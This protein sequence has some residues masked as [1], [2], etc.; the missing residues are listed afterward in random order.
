MIV[1]MKDTTWEVRPEFPRPDF[2]R[3]D[4]HNLNGAWRFAFD[5]EDV[6]LAQSWPVDGPPGERTIVVPFSWASPL[7]GIGE[8]VRG[9]GWYTRDVAWQPQH[10]DGRVILRFGAVDYRAD[11][12]VN[13][14]HVGSHEGG[15]APFDLDITPAWR[16]DGDNR[17]VVRVE[18]YDLPHQTR[19]KQGY[20]E[21]RGI[22]QPV[23]LEGRPAN[24]LL[25]VRFVTHLDGTVDVSGTIRVH[26]RGRARLT[27]SFPD[28][29]VAHAVE[30]AL[31]E[32]GEAPF[33]TSFRVEEPRLWSPDD[34][35]LYEGVVRLCTMADGADE[36]DGAGEADSAGEIDEVRTY[37]G[38]REIRAERWD[39]RP[40]RWL[41]LNGK[42]VFL[43]G[44]LDQSFHPEG[45]FTFPSDE[46]MRDE[47]WR[48]KRLGLNCV[49]IHIKPEDPRKLYWADKLGILVMAD[50]PCFW[51]EPT[52]AARSAY[53]REAEAVIHR[54]FNHPSI[55]AW[56][57]FNE[58]WGLF[59]HVDGRR[60]YTEETKAWV[61]EV[62]RWAKRL[63]PTRLVE[64]NSACNYD[65][66]ESD[67]NTWHFYIHGYEAVRDHVAHAVERTY[68]G[69]DWNYAEGYVQSDAPLMN[70]E[71]GAVWGVEGSAGDSDL[72]W[73][74]HYM[75]NEF[76]RHDKLCGFVFT[77]FHDV[78]N[79][80][81]GYYRL[82]RSDKDF[83]YPWF[84]PS[85]S[86]RTFHQ[87]DFL[88][89]DGPPCR[90]VK[91]GETVRVPV[92]KSSF[93]DTHH[94]HDLRLRWYVWYDHFGQRRIVAA[95]ERMVHWD[96][97]GVAPL[98]EIE[99]AMPGEDALAVLVVRLETPDGR[100]VAA[101]FTTFDVQSGVPGGQY[102]LP[103]RWWSVAPH[104][105]TEASF[106]LAWRALGGHKANFAHAGAVTYEVALPGIGPLRQ[107][108]GIDIF[109][110]ASAKMVLPKDERRDAVDVAA[111][112]YMQGDRVDPGRNPNSYFM[113]DEQR[114]PSWLE[115][116]VD[117]ERVAAAC[118]PDDPADARGVL[119]WHYQP[120][121]RR[122]EEAGS[123]GYLQRVTVPS[124]LLPRIVEKGGLTLTLAVP[125]ARSGGEAWCRRADGL[126]A[127]LAADA[128]AGQSGGLA[129]YG[130]N[131]GRYPMDIV[132][133]GY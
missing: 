15:Y 41:L 61:R 16:R 91:P 43:N 86:L 3:A 49:R 50:M 127:G 60:V 30:L 9:V 26:R 68:P 14:V 37:F 70:S 98:G 120:Q 113:T 76:R 89:L 84:D 95:G 124:R 71:C 66:V 10:R 69:S 7:S 17:I 38:I 32:A 46:V 4:W 130:R 100:V 22:W 131:A 39:G 78:V 47:I 48:L 83:G 64:D 25:A 92:W 45:F 108:N 104:A 2:A 122:L 90:T 87:P 111:H 18:D 81:N 62:Y 53:L 88:V 67:L 109:F 65:H 57:M 19:G 59:S 103:G 73:H 121:T 35:Y 51:G 54:D 82:D 13:G 1:T 55:F 106:P 12:W 74:Y 75:L 129:L 114:H 94:G 5:P 77:E 27:F 128:G 6:G 115:V 132:V 133:W 116:Y 105:Y 58:T 126:A 33:A 23:W 96:G 117:G 85:L 44:T 125:G 34:P 24:H 93:T 112:D 36:T 107:L 102:D 119:S 11:V 56:V 28:G 80:W 29:G 21:I 63:D 8:D 72:A 101:N 97:Y 118:L 123:Y 40:Y 31:P 99:A 79:E 42:P 110:E 20:G 52:E